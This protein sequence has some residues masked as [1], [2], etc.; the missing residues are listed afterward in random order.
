MVSNVISMPAPHVRKGLTLVEVIVAMLVF[1]VGA[2]GLAAGS[3]VVARQIASTTLRA[4]AMTIARS[5]AERASA[6]GCSAS[7][8][9]EERRLGVRSV[10]RSSGGSVVTLD[11]TLEWSTQ[12]G[13]RSDRFLSSV[14]CA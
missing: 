14:P 13:V 6:Q 9:G 12:S 5:R 1:T 10:W 4:N 7:T 2:L 3:A 8:S 11:Q